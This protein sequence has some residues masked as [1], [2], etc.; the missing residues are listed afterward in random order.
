MGPTPPVPSRRHL[1]ERGGKRAVTI[2]RGRHSL[3]PIA[4]V[5][6]FSV[7]FAM[8]V[9][10]LFLYPVKSLRGFSVP[11]AEIDDLG[12][13]GDRRFLVIDRDNRFLTQRNVPRMTLVATALDA[14]ALTLSAEGA[15]TIRVPRPPDASA[16]RRIVAVWRSEGLETEDCGDAVA[17]W[18]SQVLQLSCRLVR[19][20][21]DYV[22]PVLKPAAHRGD[23]VSFADSVPFLVL[24][25]ASL[26]D[27]ND[28]LAAR[29]EEPV[30]MNRFRPNIVLADTGAFAEDTWPRFRIGG[31]TFRAAG[32]CSRCPVTTTD[33][34][35]GERGKEPLRTLAT[36]R[37]DATDP[38]DVMFGQNVIHETKSGLIRVGDCVDLF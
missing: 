17:A 9:S 30:P 29:G 35:T 36:Y 22:R 26:N 4:P 38:T 13:V 32:P 16:P 31:V 14:A 20:G 27:L 25:E 28:R 1:P 12:F 6:P 8:H 5:A 2:A 23:R 33:Q 10:G 34:F 7:A 18:L 11:Q 24:G 19:I 3:F 21:P 15:G 37:R